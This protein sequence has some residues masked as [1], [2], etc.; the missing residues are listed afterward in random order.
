MLPLFQKNLKTKKQYKISNNKLLQIMSL[1]PEIGRL[2]KLESLDVSG[3]PIQRLPLHIAGC[4]GLEV[5][6]TCHPPPPPSPSFPSPAFLFLSALLLQLKP[7][8]QILNASGCELVDVPEEFC[9][10]TRLIELNFS[11]NQVP[12]SSDISSSPPSSPSSFSLRPSTSLA[13]T[14]IADTSFTGRD[15]QDDTFDGPKLNVQPTQRF[16]DFCRVKLSLP[17]SCLPKKLKNKTK[18]NKLMVD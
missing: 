4:R 17:L 2:Y 16:A 12:S 14:F 9:L 5:Y 10:L 18:Q 13:L 15:W 1:N 3:N 8:F 6:F 11:N 7:N